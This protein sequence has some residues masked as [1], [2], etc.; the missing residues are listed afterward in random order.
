MSVNTFLKQVWEARLLANYNKASIAEVITTPP[1]EMNGKTITFNKTGGIQVSDYTGK[2]EWQDLA[3]TS[4][5]LLMDQKKTFSFVVDDIDKVQAAGDLVEGH[6]SD[7]AGEVNTHIDSYVLGLYT[8]AHEDNVIGT[9]EEPKKLT[10]DNVY[11]YIVDLGTKLS[12]KKVPKADRFV[13]VNAAVLNLLAKDDRF[14]RNPNV[15]ENGVVEG[16]KINGLQVVE[17]EELIESDGKLHIVANHKQAVGYGK[18]IDNIETLRLQDTHGDGVRG[19]VVFGSTVLRPEGV[20][21]L[22]A[23]IGEKETG[24]VEG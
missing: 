7:A 19:L 10:K 1:V 8:D 21:V 12:Q 2:I 18:Q 17:S 14:T 6:M 3:T 20:A 24:G 11:D 9:S 4:V 23:T 13:T 15:L 5:D 16:Q 22:T